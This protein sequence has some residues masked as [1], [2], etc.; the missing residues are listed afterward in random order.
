MG[1]VEPPVGVGVDAGD[2]GVRGVPL[3]DQ[4]GAQPVGLRPG[5]GRGVLQSLGSGQG[6]VAGGGGGGDRLG[7]VLPCLGER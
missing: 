6:G 1:R 7:G 3:T 5:L 4:I 2:L